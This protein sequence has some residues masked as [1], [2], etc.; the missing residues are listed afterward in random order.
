[1][2]AKSAWIGGVVFLAAAGMYGYT[3]AVVGT[4]S[5]R[6]LISEQT[7]IVNTV[8]KT[9]GAYSLLGSTGQLGYG[10]LAGSKYTVDWGVVNSW[11]PPQDTLS[12]SH[13]YP[14][15]CSLRNSCNGVTFTALTLTATITVYTVA[16]EKVRTLQKDSNIDS[17]GWDLRNDAG[18]RVAS[19]LYLYVITSP[20]S[21]KKGKMVIVR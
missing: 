15:P 4:P 13:V 9:G 2:R 3:S 20:G 8:P 17:L 10:S 19:G 12:A 21:S 6:I 14:N 11:R 1:M 16:G 18:Q 5:Y 7:T